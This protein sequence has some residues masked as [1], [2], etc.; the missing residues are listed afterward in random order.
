MVDKTELRDYVIREFDNALADR[1]IKVYYQPVIRSISSELCGLEAL[2]RWDSPGYGLLPPGD[3]ISALENSGQIFK[4][5][6][7]VLH[8]VCRSMR[9]R[10]SQG[11]PT[12]PVSFNLSRLDFISCD[13]F[14]EVEAAVRDYE[15]QRDML[16]LEITES[17]MAREPELIE[18][19]V[20]K[21]Q[22]AG[23]QV[24]IDDFGSGYSSLNLLKDHNYD[25][26]KIDMGFLRSFTEKSKQIITSIVDMAKRINIRTLA[27]G[28]ETVEQFEFLRN[29]GCEKLQGYFFGRPQPL[30]DAMLQCYEQGM[31]IERRMWHNYYDAIGRVNFITDRALA[32]AEF[33]GSSIELIYMN[34]HYKKVLQRFG[35]NA[36]ENI[37][38]NINSPASPLYRQ[39]RKLH[40]SIPDGDVF[41]DID[42]AVR[43]EYMRIRARRIAR[44]QYKNAYHI[45]IQDLSHKKGRAREEKLDESLRMMYLMYDAVYRMNL[46]KDS[47]ETVMRNAFYDHKVIKN[48]KGCSIAQAIKQLAFESIYPA[49]RKHFMEWTDISTIEDRIRLKGRGFISEYFR[50]REENGSYVW[51]AHRIMMITDLP[52]RELIY[53]V[54]ETP[55]DDMGTLKNIAFSLGVDTTNEETQGAILWKSLLDSNSAHIF[56]KDNNRKFTGANRNFLDFFGIEDESILLGKDDE[57][58]GWHLDAE[59]FRSDELRVLNNGETLINRVGK[60]LVRGAL[61]T[62]LATKVPMYK[63]GEIVGLLGYFI[64]VDEF[65]KGGDGI[66]S[67]LRTD[68]LTGLLN[69]AGMLTVLTDY[70]EQLDSFGKSFALIRINISQYKD[71]VISYGRKTANRLLKKVARIIKEESGREA[72]CGRIHS[73]NYN[74]CIGYSE[75]GSVELLCSRLAERISD[76]HKVAGYSVTV[77]PEINVVY[78]DDYRDYTELI[79][80]IADAEQRC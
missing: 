73:G 46:D 38:L 66:E 48:P 64:D 76:I 2:A 40:Q 15:I 6:L 68:A 37:D 26:I 1:Q 21:F 29:I 42:Y 61:H 43:G 70:V 27:E 16:H 52:H 49:D 14:S 25:E 30:E 75:R 77:N 62:I 80:I 59:P 18:N 20:G 39:F 10:I 57:E 23:Y 19:A 74:I 32:V 51:K 24:W 34:E 63:N 17:M 53:S 11:L 8:E 33:D 65:T 5:D 54:M 4:L 47:I 3:F 13:I 50:T 78:A 69:T 72:C 60:C 44:Q 22:K 7:Y 56:W 35:S 71:T 28:V 12:V 79:R 41:Q 31:G 36:V 9:M 67:I 45:S 58:M 55:L